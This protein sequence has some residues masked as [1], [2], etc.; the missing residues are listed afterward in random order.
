MKP[1]DDFEIS[2]LNF[3]AFSL[4]A[5]ISLCICFILYETDEI[6]MQLLQLGKYFHKSNS[7]QIQLLAEMY[8]V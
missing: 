6:H 5:S 7:N 3:S 1:R 8:K 2:V 4:K